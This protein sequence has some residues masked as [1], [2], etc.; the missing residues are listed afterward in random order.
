[1]SKKKHSPEWML[2]RIE[3]YLSGQGSYETIARANG[4]D[5]KTLR[6]WVKK[7][8]IHGAAAFVIRSGDA[9]YSK[10][11]KLQTVLSTRII[12]AEAESL[13]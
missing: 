2:A 4:I 7:Y 10:E 9:H 5:K 8:R 1:M 13:S 6:R 12:T 3:E 11:F